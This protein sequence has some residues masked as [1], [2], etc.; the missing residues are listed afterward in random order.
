MSNCASVH[1]W[2]IFAERGGSD[3]KGRVHEIGWRLF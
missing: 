3:K 1:S 2:K